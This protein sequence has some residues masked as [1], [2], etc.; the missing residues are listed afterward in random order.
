M[1]LIGST[2]S[3]FVR[4]LRL[5]LADH[6]YEFISLDIFSE[7]DRKFLTQNNPTLK[8]PALIDD[9]QCIYDSRVIYRYLAQKFKMEKISW[10]QENLLTLIDAAN[11]SFVTLLLTDRSGIDNQQD[12]LFFNLQNERVEKLLTVLADEVS[13]GEFT[14]W[15]YPAIC[16]FC[17]LDWVIF[18][19]LY[20][21]NKFPHLIEFWQQAKNNAM[22]SESDP[23][24]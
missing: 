17:L 13:K 3:P 2:T 6:E 18:R 8:V 4:R 24:T 23:R 12:V 10:E 21:V 19:N 11:D 14:T 20:E 5:F 15:H 22:V 7:Q 1:K 9:E 16:L